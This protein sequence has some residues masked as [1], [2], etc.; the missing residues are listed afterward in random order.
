MSRRHS[1]F[2]L[3]KQGFSGHKGWPQAW[4]KAKF[5]RKPP[6]GGPAES[7]AILAGGAPLAPGRAPRDQPRLPSRFP[8]GRLIDEAAGAGS[9]I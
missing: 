2:A 8:A 6:A 4:R 7:K 3:V 9:A 5:S 1:G